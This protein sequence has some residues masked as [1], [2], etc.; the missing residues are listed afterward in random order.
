MILGDQHQNDLKNRQKTTIN[1]PFTEKGS[2]KTVKK[3]RLARKLET[4]FDTG[5]PS[6]GSGHAVAH[7]HRARLH[8]LHTPQTT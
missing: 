5:I 4:T 7:A 6:H 1:T 3:A 8:F 2:K